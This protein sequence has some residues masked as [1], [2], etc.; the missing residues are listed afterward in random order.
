MSNL[1]NLMALCL[2]SEV[3]ELS[4]RAINPTCTILQSTTPSIDRLVSKAHGSNK[5]HMCNAEAEGYMYG[6]N[7]RDINHRYT[8]VVP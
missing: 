4:L 6:R 2:T 5:S 8:T 1:L 3:H 7:T